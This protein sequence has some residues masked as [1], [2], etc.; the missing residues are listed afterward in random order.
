MPADSWADMPVEKI[1]FGLKKLA[2]GFW[3]NK[4]V[5][6]TALF[7]QLK[8]FTGLNQRLS[9]GETLGMI[10]IDEVIDILLRSTITSAFW[11]WLGTKAARYFPSGEI[12]RD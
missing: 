6:F 7:H 1:Q 5:A 11:L 8:F 4:A 10:R 12:R 9:Q 2:P 3:I